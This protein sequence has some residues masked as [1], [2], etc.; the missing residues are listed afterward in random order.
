ME[1]DKSLK[2][3][4]YNIKLFSERSLSRLFSI[5]LTMIVGIVILIFSVIAA[6]YNNAKIEARQLQRLEKTLQ[7]AETSLPSS[8]W[9]LDYDSMSDMLNAIFTDDTII[10]AEIIS[11]SETLAKKTHLRFKHKVF[12]FFKD[13]PHF[14]VDTV[15]IN[16][17]E[18]KIGTFHIVMSREKIRKELFY[19]L[20]GIALFTV[21]IIATISFTC[22]YLT[23]QYIFEPLLKLEHSTRLIARGNLDESIVIENKNEIGQLAGSILN[24]RGAIKEKIRELKKA[25]KK[26]KDIFDKAIEGIFQCT[27]GGYFINVNQSAASLLGYDSPEDMIS[28]IKDVTNNLYVNTHEQ[29][30]SLRTLYKKGKILDLEVQIR[31]KD[32]SIIWI[33]VN[34]RQIRNSAGK[35]TYY[36]GSFLDITQRKEA[37]YALQDNLNRYQLLLKA[38]PIPIIVYNSKGAVTYVNP[39]FTDIFGWTMD[40][41]AGKK[42]DFVPPHEVEKTAKAVKETLEGK[43]ASIE[44]QRFTKE[45]KLLDVLINASLYTDHDGIAE[46]MIV[47]FRDFTVLKQAQRELS[48]HRDQLEQM[49]KERT[50]E[51]TVSNKRLSE[52][53]FEH[54]ATESALKN[55]EERFRQLAEMLPETVFEMD[56][57]ANFTFRNKASYKMFGYKDE[58]DNVPGNALENIVPEDHQRVIENCAKILEGTPSMGNEYTAIKKDGSRFPIMIYTNALMK[59]DEAI[60]FRG[61]LLDISERKQLEE[62]LRLAKEQADQA[63]KTKSEFLANMSH[64]IRTPMNAILGM[65]DLLLES[66]LSLEQQKYLKILCNSGDNLLEIINDI[67]DLSKVEAGQIELETISINLNDLIDKI[68]ALLAVRAHSKGLEL[69]CHIKTGTPVYLL[70]DPARLRQIMVNLLGNAIKFTSRGEIL[71]EVSPMETAVPD[72]SGDRIKLLFSVRD[73]GIGIPEEKQS[74]IF[75]SFAQADSSTTRDFGGTGLGLTI[76]KRMVEMMGGRIWV[77]SKPGKGCTFFFTAD[78]SLDR[79]YKPQDRVASVN[80][81]GINVLVVDDNA[82][83]RL[84]L[85]ETLSSWG[86]EVSEAENGADALEEIKKREKDGT[87]FDLVLLDGKMPVM[88]GFETLKQ[89]NNLFHHLNHTMMMLTSDDSPSRIASARKN[90]A[91]M[92]L[93]KPV[94]QK[95]LKQAVSSA[96]GRAVSGKDSGKKIL[97]AEKSTEQESLRIL[98]V[99]DGRE[100]RMLIKAF[101]KKTPHTIDEAENGKIG[102]DKF[103]SGEYDMVLMDM[104][105][106]VMDG[107]TAVS[108]IRKWEHA[109][110]KPA[111]FIIALTAHAMKGDRQKCLDAGCSDYLPKPIKKT[112]LLKTIEKGTS[113]PVK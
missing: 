95:E 22:I 27:P 90:G 97:S 55:S 72:N 92:C 52:E 88:D 102:L 112:D 40:E 94:R 13:S 59:D 56:L 57:F 5:A 85:K 2:K 109:R 70:G 113:Q 110:G 82:T 104:R 3:R 43:H 68:C 37:Q 107:Y 100:N 87:P 69:L 28:S 51:L 19:N 73:T 42:I 96:L 67:L 53:I 64:E 44:S 41:L 79:H 38:S 54:K 98:V 18:Q 75:E 7:L 23:K 81:P 80:I 99:D 29:E 86:A 84:I 11:D 34:A 101:L 108:E 58:A 6:F 30:Q 78:F 32:R 21:F 48:R 31:R 66:D 36:E 25:E 74:H 12:S 46:G 91:E 17:N 9:Q 20:F 16:K 1:M 71:L 4:D 10:F 106:P 77:E 49:V 26:Y 65:G 39:S 105:M 63:S 61:I 8:V 45:K 14:L 93:I 24:M 89:I 50:S 60:G 111:V 76:S 47:T 35:I 33:S 62:D 103:Q 83:N 15:N